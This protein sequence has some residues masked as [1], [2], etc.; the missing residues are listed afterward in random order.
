MYINNNGQRVYIKHLKLRQLHETFGDK[1]A[2]TK[3]CKE[4]VDKSYV[5]T[6]YREGLLNCSWWGKV[7]PSAVGGDKLASYYKVSFHGIIKL[8]NKFDNIKMSSE[9]KREV[10]KFMLGSIRKKLYNK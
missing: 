4:V 2:T 10:A 1:W 5:R 3:E 6:L 8:L 9:R 7:R